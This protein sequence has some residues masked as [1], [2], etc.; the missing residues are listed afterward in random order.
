MSN[1]VRTL[2]LV[3]AS[4]FLALS[5]AVVL[6]VA[7]EGNNNMARVAFVLGPPMLG[8]LVYTFGFFRPDSSRA[9]STRLAGWFGMALGLYSLISFSFVVV[10]L[11]ALTLPAAI[12]KKS[13]SASLAPHA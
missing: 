9:R 12:T 4:L 7:S 5:L 13:P 3:G 1:V 8:A 6:L 10:P 11:L 2:G